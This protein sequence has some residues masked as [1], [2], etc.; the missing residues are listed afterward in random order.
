[1]SANI[2]AQ[3]TFADR[4]G[5]ALR[6]AEAEGFGDKAHFANKIGEE[7]RDLLRWSQGTKMPAHALVALLGE[8]PRHLADELIKPS[9]LRLVTREHLDH[10]N[11]LKAA[12]SASRFSGDVAERMADGEWC[13]RDAEAARQHAQR[14]ITDLQSLAGE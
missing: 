10:A 5:N 3:Q 8:L 1:M 4:L 11:A 7:A 14:V 12:A 2:A 6:R 9:G 13:H